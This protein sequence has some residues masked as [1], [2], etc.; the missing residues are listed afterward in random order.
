VYRW[1]SKYDNLHHDFKEN[2]HEVHDWKDRCRIWDEKYHH[3]VSDLEYER[4]E[5]HKTIEKS[6]EWEDKYYNAHLKVSVVHEYEERV[7]ILEKE[8]YDYKDELHVLEDRYRHA[9]SDLDH[10][11]GK[12]EHE[13]KKSHDLGERLI[14]L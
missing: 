10:W 2:E 9:L 14:H 3:I 1:E 13:K 12:L 7:H 11:P 8:I 4:D 5:H 6:H